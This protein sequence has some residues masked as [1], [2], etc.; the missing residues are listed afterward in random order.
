MTLRRN[1]EVVYVKNNKEIIKFAFPA[2]VENFLQM[3]VGLSDTFLV[4]RISLSAVAAVSLSN[5]IIAVYQALFIAIGTIVAS[6]YS[7]RLVDGSKESR[8]KIVDSGLKLTG[9]VGLVL[10]LVSLFLGSFL[11]NLFGAR[12]EVLTLSYDYLALVGGTII[13]LGLMTTFGSFLRAHGDSTTPMLASLLVNVVNLLLAAVFIF[14]FHWGVIGAALGTV[15]ARLLGTI[16]LYQKIKEE[17]PSRQFWRLK[18]DKEL[19]RMT[20]P[21]AGERL[22]MR[23]GDLLIMMLV[24][25]FGEKVF[26]GNAIGESITQFNYMP[27]F[28][29]ATVTVVLIAQEFGK[30]DFENIKR[31]IRKTMLLSVLMMAVIGGVIL[32]F[33][34]QLSQMFTSDAVA[35]Q[36]SDTVILFS[37]I[38][39]F[40]V[41]G[42]NIYTAAFQGIGN[43]KLPF[44]ATTFGMLVVRTLFGLFFGHF[45]G[46]GLEGV[47]FGVILD[48]LFRF[49]FL[50]YKFKQVSTI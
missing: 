39:I 6:L 20:F 44:Y 11:V 10:G 27:M 48:N 13:L 23:L 29:I 49:L 50:R 36:S 46:L 1:A 32:A 5:N 42:A 26:A 3:L 31:Y 40:F 34:H 35:I 9:I 25:S 22:S 28:G 14:V 7:R 47:W 24:I 12:G 4:T 41:T 8:Q 15:I 30:H 2:M 45:L 19:V 33:A 37:F 38:A 16:Y 43:A 18:L 17:R 21:A